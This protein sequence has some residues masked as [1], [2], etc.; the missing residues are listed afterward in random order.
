MKLFVLITLLGGLAGCGAGVWPAKP[1]SSP[2][3]INGGINGGDAGLPPVLRPNPSTTAPV[4]PN[5]TTPAQ[6]DTTTAADR[7]AAQSVAGSGQHLGRS[8]ASLGNPAEPG[9]W[10]K[11]TLVETPSSGRIVWRDTGQDIAV[12]L[13][14]I[15]GAP[16]AGSEISLAAMRLLGMDLTGLPE[17]DIFLLP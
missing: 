17:I 6:F 12:D 2:G 5:A 9:F 15:P 10:V 8:I 13:L 3:G 7:T 4:N 16:T 11:T 14:P 1:A